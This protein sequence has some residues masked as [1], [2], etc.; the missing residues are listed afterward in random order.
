MIDLAFVINVG[1][2]DRSTTF[3]LIKDTIK[4]IAAKYRMSRI[5]Y[6][7]IIYGRLATTR[8]SFGSNFPDENSFNNSIDSL[9]L[10]SGGPNLGEALE[11]AKEVF[12]GPGVRTNSKKV[13]V[14]IGNQTPL[15][16]SSVLLSSATMLSHLGVKIVSVGIGGSIDPQKLEQFTTR[17]KANLLI[18]DNSI[19]PIIFG[20]RIMLLVLKGR[21]TILLWIPYCIPRLTYNRSVKNYFF[22]IC[23]TL[24]QCQIHIW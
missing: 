8:I 2:A 9:V 24:S 14:V 19:R 13:V 15:T 3:Q 7:V 12:S 16:N 23:L 21:R 6:S 20:K 11:R 5:R 17:G 10:S 4:S 22:G 1:G 18:V